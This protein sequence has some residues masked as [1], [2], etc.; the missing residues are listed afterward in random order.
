MN[1]L[2]YKIASIIQLSKIIIS[3]LISIILLISVIFPKRFIALKTFKKIII[4]LTLFVLLG[5]L[6]LSFLNAILWKNDPLSYHLLPPYTPI[7]YIISYSWY[8]YW[9]SPFLAIV[10][11]YLIFFSIQK[12]NQRFNNNFFYDEESYLAALGI[13]I[14]GWPNC[15][16][17]LS[18]VLLLGILSHVL[19]VILTVL[20]DVNNSPRKVS[21][22]PN[23]HGSSERNER[24][25]EAE[26]QAVVSAREKLTASFRVNYLRLSLLYFWPLCSLLTLLLNDLLNKYL[27][28]MSLVSNLKI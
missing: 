13:L 26:R 14:T 9:L 16:I 25:N 3:Y 19:I 12:I 17:Y 24:E 7:G 8:H 10:F 11:A 4:G 15:L 1:N 5:A 28:I 20:K 27:N 18:L 6:S 22:R 2:L 23:G 21:C